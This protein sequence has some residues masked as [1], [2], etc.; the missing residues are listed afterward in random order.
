[1]P[2]FRRYYRDEKANPGK[3]Y[4]T[5]INGRG[6]FVPYIVADAEVSTLKSRYGYTWRGI[7]RPHDRELGI[8]GSELIIFDL[9]SNEILAVRRG[10]VRSGGV[11][12]NLTGVWWLTAP[13]CPNRGLKTT[14]MFI[15][16]VLN[17]VA[18]KKETN[19]AAH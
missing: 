18:L 13:S 17:P 2:K 11:R 6:V 5:M 7:K 15:Q 9:Q 3:K 19:D 16:Q 10:F 1:M 14:P 8:A 4:Q 12:N